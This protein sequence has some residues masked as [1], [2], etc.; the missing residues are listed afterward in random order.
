M[1]RGLVLALLACAT[2]TAAAQSPAPTFC[3]ADEQVIFSCATTRKR[4]ISLCATGPLTKTAGTLQY[5]FG[6]I[7]RE[8]ELV[9]PVPVAHPTGY[10]VSG[11]V[12]YSGGGG[13]YIKFTHEGDAYAV[14]TGIG[15]GWEKAGLLVTR[16]GRVIGSQLCE[17][18]VAS[19]IGPDL[20][21]RAG[22]GHD[23]RAFEF[24]IP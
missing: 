12:T 5:R 17:K 18:P 10:F 1:R 21:E 9:W 19:E 13:A 2:A 3:S 23:P 24:E 20:F 15:R 22:L 7:E 11:T 16:S 6:T 8:M 14:Y 4:I